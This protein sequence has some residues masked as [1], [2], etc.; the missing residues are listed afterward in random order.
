MLSLS[1]CIDP[2]KDVEKMELQQAFF[3]LMGT[4]P[5][6]SVLRRVEFITSSDRIVF[7]GL[8]DESKDLSD[9]RKCLIA[10]ELPGGDPLV[11]EFG[12]N[13]RK[14]GRVVVYSE[15]LELSYDLY[16]AEDRSGLFCIGVYLVNEKGGPSLFYFDAKRLGPNDV[17]ESKLWKK[18][19]K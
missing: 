7:G 11:K 10:T 17:K 6:S 5:I 3:S 1:G 4:S 8:G 19:L 14:I 2:K 12:W 16:E 13:R 15:E 9:L 18:L